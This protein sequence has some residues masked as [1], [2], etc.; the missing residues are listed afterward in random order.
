MVE[1]FIIIQNCVMF[2]ELKRRVNYVDRVECLMVQSNLVSKSS[3]FIFK[4]CILC[5]IVY[6]W[7]HVPCAFVAQKNSSKINFLIAI[8]FQHFPMNF[9]SLF[10]FFFSFFFLHGWYEN[11][12]LQSIFSEF[13]HIFSCVNE[14]N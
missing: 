5:S 8:N 2:T 9:I 11:L 3:V 6:G 14:R 10:H 4:L 13:Q 1:S 7:M 12:P